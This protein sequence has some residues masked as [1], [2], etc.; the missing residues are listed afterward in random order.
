MFPV[1][2]GYYSR[3]KRNRR[4]WLG[5]ISG[6]NK[7]YYVLC[8]N[9]KLRLF[10]TVPFTLFLIHVVLGLSACEMKCCLSWKCI[11]SVGKVPTGNKKWFH[12]EHFKFLNS[13]YD[14]SCFCWLLPECNNI[15][16]LVNKRT[17]CCLSICR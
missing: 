14:I 12:M 8:E 4:Q 7:V 2:P 10:K 17:R 9:S 6:R 15:F 1:S 16:L 5:K 11:L 3:P 13:R